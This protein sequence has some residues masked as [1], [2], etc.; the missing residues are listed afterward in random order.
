MNARLGSRFGREK[1]GAKPPHPDLARWIVAC[2]GFVVVTVGLWGAPA[3][4]WLARH[5]AHWA[6]VVHQRLP[7]FSMIHQ[8]LK[9]GAVGWLCLTGL[10]FVWTALVWTHWHWRVGRVRGHYLTV[11]IPRP[12]RRRGTGMNPEA[13]ALLWDRLIATL[14]TSAPYGMSPY[15]ATELW[16]DASGRVAWGVWLPDHIHTQ[17]EVVRRLM[18][19]ERPEA[20]LVDAADPLVGAL[21]RRDEDPDDAGT[22]WYAGALVILRARD[23]YPLPDD[24]LALRSVVAALRPPRTV[25]ASG[26]SVIVTPAPHGW[27]ARVHRLVR[28]WRWEARSASSLD[29]RRKQEIDDISLKAQQAHAW[30]SLRVH[31]IAHSR[32]AALHECRGLLTTLTTSRK[33]Y[34][35]VSQFWQPRRVRVWQIH[36]TRLPAGGR[37][38]APFRPLPR[39]LPLFPFI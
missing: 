8:G 27:A 23:Y 32:A 37:A 21:R 31:V 17:R 35:D 36:G 28:R 20:R 33:R 24:A 22:R 26:V 13:S 14:H 39:L 29:E 2:V 10:G 7:M 4:W 19:A 25:F 15:L 1:H 18:T 6:D 38:R 34:A 5:N 3:A 30:V 12:Q 11:V 9:Y 16:G